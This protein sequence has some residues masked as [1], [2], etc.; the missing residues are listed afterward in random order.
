VRHAELPEVETI[1]AGLRQGAGGPASLI[2]RRIRQAY[3]LWE[4]SLAW[5]SPAEILDWL[6][7]QFIGDIRRRGKFIVFDLSQH[8]P[9]GAPAHERRPA[10]GAGHGAPG[11][12]HHRLVIEPGRGLRLA[13][14][15]PQFG[16]VW[17]T[18]DRQSVLGSLGS[19]APGRNFHRQD[20]HQMLARSPAPAKAAAAR[21][22]LSWLAWG[23]F[24][25]TKSCMWLACPF[26]HL[27]QPLAGASQRLWQSIRPG[28]SRRHPAHGAS[29]DWVYRAGIPTLF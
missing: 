5:P 13:L 1:A 22:E 28:A 16:R 9:A 4:R 2:G 19:R 25:P 17:L 3:L 6:P 29:I 7:G 21:S 24:T 14:T 15:M 11:A 10:G 26:N 27:K 8:H 20:L 23:T 12:P 18:A